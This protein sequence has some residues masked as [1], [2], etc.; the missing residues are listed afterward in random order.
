MT[1]DVFRRTSA[2]VVASVGG[3]QLRWLDRVLGAARPAGVRWLVVQGHTPVL[4]ARTFSSSGALVAGGRGS[5]L[6]RTLV[7]HRVDLYVAGEVH[8]VSARRAG[9]GIRGTAAG[10]PG[11]VRP[12][13]T[14]HAEVAPLRTVNR[15]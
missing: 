7:R 8:V 9:R 14:A 15:C 4:P 12:A 3:G 5:P 11:L 6:W 2:G 1:L 13:L 10:S